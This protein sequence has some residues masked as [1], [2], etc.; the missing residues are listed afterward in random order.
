MRQPISAEEK[1]AV[2]LRFLATGETYQSLKYQFRIHNSTIS[3]FVPKVCQVIYDVLKDDYFSVPSSEQEW[4]NL[5]DATEKRWQFP[6][7]FAAADGKHIAVYHP[8]NSGGTFYNYKGFYS[9]VLLAFVDYDYKFIYADVGC[10]GRISDG[11]VYRNSSFAEKLSALE[12]NLPPARPLPRSKNPAWTPYE[13]EEDIPFVFVADSAFSLSKHC[14]KPY[15]EKGCDDKR[16]IFNYRLSRLRRVTENAFGI[17][18]AVFR[19]FSTKINV[20][21]DKATKI[22]KAALVLHNMLRS[23]SPESYTPA[24]FADEVVDD[25]VIDGRW[26]EGNT[27]SFLEPLPA[28]LKGNKPKVSAEKIREIFA[29]HFYGPGEVPWQWKCLV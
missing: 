18:T 25:N 3:L 11:G 1:L 17:L 9:I 5:A 24:G 16:R 15:P 28:R 20:N 8:D 12:L 29:E 10:Q 14:M 22:V 26:R 13:N 23:K 19:I 4:I 27:G 6:N 2:T 7:A 21:P